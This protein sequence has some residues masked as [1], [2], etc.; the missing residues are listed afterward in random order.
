ASQHH[1][2]ASQQS[3]AASQ[4][5]ARSLKRYLV[6]VALFTLGNSSDA[7]LL[8]RARESGFDQSGLTLLW[9]LHNLVK[10]VLSHRMGALSDRVG[11]RT[12]IAGGWLVYALSYAGFAVARAP[13]QMVLL[14]A[15]YG[16]YY[17]MAEGPERAMVADLAPA[18]RRGTAFGW[19]YATTGLLALP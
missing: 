16:L 7:F 19:F 9:T 13:W 11:R 6:A 2:N 5:N 15:V 14:F 1:D 12:L 10:T 18:G 4:N 3:D 8:L 17:A